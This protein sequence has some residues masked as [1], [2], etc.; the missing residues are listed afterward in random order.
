[1]SFG[2]IARAAIPSDLT[3]WTT[4]DIGGYDGAYTRDCL[5]RGAGRCTVVDN[6]EW[7]QYG[8]INPGC[9][10]GARYVEADLFGWEEPADLVLFGNVLYHL[11][12]PEAG[13]AHLRTL[14]RR[15]MVLWTSF[16]EHPN[17]T[18]EE[19]GWRWY[20]DGSGHENGTVWCRPIRDGL[21]RSLRRAGFR[22]IQEVGRHGDHIVVTAH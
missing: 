22:D 10:E 15:L 12:D 2:E 7:R 14:T 20:P 5:K 17:G 13:L 16:A 8:W 3:G 19:S 9:P 18:E 6:G 1:M 4:L 21:P 11:R